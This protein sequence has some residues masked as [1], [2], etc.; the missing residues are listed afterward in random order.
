M[1]IKDIID[2][3]DEVKPN[4]YSDKQKVAW[5]N[6]V[7]EEIV[8]EVYHRSET[9]KSY[10]FIPCSQED[11]DKELLVPDHFSDLYLYFL[12]AKIDAL[13]GEAE[14][15][16]NDTVLFNAA[17]DRYSCYMNRTHKPVGLHNIEK[18]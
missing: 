6:E 7:E 13:R 15:Y 11:M 18:W 5:L 17:W 1:K 9:Y 4:K 12:A 3:L 14:R 10:E 8:D 16:N 2:M